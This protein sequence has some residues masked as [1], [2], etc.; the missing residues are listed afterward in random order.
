M[1]MSIYIQNKKPFK[2]TS[3]LFESLTYTLEEI[4]EE[5]AINDP[6]INHFLSEMKFTTETMYPIFDVSESLKTAKGVA[7]VINLLEKAKAKMNCDLTRIG[8][9]ILFDF[10]N[11]LME[12]Y[13][14]LELK[15]KA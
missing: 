8:Q 12:Y 7:I 10:H 9:E 6:E 14:E 2:C 1:S 4:S 15:E 5:Q 3:G 13:Q 11:G